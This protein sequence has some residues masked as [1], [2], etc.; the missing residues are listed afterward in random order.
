MHGHASTRV[1]SVCTPNV[2]ARTDAPAHTD[3]PARTPDMPA[4]TDTP[5]P[6]CR[7][8]RSRALAIMACHATAIYDAVSQFVLPL[9]ER[10]WTTGQCTWATTPV[11]PSPVSPSPVSPSPVSP[12]PVSPSPV[13]PSPVSPSP[14]YCA[15][16]LI[17]TQTDYLDSMLDYPAGRRTSMADACTSATTCGYVVGEGMEADGRAGGV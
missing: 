5:A 12:S 15:T 3:A 14:A 7:R 1:V 6:E 10:S 2:P 13:S 16:S 4:R 11:S 9:L 17:N 8:F